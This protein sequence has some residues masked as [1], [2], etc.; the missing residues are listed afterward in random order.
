MAKKVVVFQDPKDQALGL[1][2]YAGV[3]VPKDTVFLFPEVPPGTQIH[4][5]GMGESIH[6]YMLDDELKTYFTKQC[7]A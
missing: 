3:G 2:R 5:R 7:F 6:V 4:S 1:L